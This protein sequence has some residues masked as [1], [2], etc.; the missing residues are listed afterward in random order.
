MSETLKLTR[1]LIE[2][3][4]VTPED[5]GCQSLLAERLLPLGF[6]VEWMP[7]GNVSNVLFT[8]GQAVGHDEPSLWFLGHTDVVPPGPLEDWTSPP[9]KAEVRNGVLYGRGA[10]DM[11]GAV[12]AMVTAAEDL[13][14][15]HPSHRGQIGI[16]L[17]SDEEGDAVDGVKRVAAVL[18][19]RNSAPSF[20]VVGEPSSRTRLGDTVRI[21]RR[22]STHARLTIH[23]IQGHSAFPQDLDNPIH[24]LATFLDELTKMQWDQGD[25]NF[26]PTHC[27]V[28]NVHSGTGAENVTPG[29]AEAWFN[30]RNSPASPNETI[31]SRIEELLKQQGIDRYDLS[32]RVSGEAFRSKAGKLRTAVNDTI[33]EELGIQPE[34]N[35]GGGTSDGR[36]I[37]P[38]GTETLEFGLLN[39]SIHKIDENT[40]VED[41]EALSRVYKRVMLQLLV[42]GAD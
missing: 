11:K 14:R 29:H 28:T 6:D 3:A 22:G 39:E 26:P 7:F 20:C 17:T 21:G 25:E 12:A 19:E 34:L 37:A 5:A 8:H 18:R 23:G 16:L 40:P 1:A 38:L 9:F 42:N 4:S 31:R 33:V 2:L 10:S 36:F 35:T 15:E 41:L 30:F 24:R 32:W 27:Q 13:V